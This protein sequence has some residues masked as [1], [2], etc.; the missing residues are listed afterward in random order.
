MKKTVV[1]WVIWFLC[2][3]VASAQSYNIGDLYTAPDGSKGVVYYLFPDGNGGWAVALND[4]SAGCAWGNASDVPGLTNHNPSYAQNLLIDTAGYTNTLTLRAYYNANNDAAGVL[5]FAHGW[6]L[7]S[8]AQLRMLYGQL[9]YVFSAITSAGGTEM[10]YDWYWTST[11][12]NGSE[13]WCVDFGATTSSGG[14]VQKGKTTS[15]RV[16]AICYIN[17]SLI[18]YDTSLTNCVV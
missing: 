8:A 6:F 15:N 2:S 16:R 10:S 4:A 3:F 14:L 1:L 17:P 11:E 5:D 9:P 12:R 7:P 18:L 13:A